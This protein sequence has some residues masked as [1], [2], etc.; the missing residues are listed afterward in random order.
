MN[1]EEAYCT[2]YIERSPSPPEHR[3]AAT[4]PQISDKEIVIRQM[5]Y[6][7]KIRIKPKGS[8]DRLHPYDSFNKSKGFFW[9]VINE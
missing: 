2:R 6:K 4:L 9:I 5:L 1:L 8:V 3:L 7:N